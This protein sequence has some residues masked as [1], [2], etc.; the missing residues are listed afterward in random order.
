MRKTQ[1]KARDMLTD[2]YRTN[3]EISKEYDE[4]N[5]QHPEQKWNAGAKVLAAVI[6]L[7]LIGIVIKYI[8]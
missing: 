4:Y 5:R 6:V 1:N 3:R 2:Y 7:G 8:F